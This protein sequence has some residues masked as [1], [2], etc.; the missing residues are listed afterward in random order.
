VG[1][2][3]VNESFFRDF[4]TLLPVT[5]LCDA[6]KECAVEESKEIWVG[7]LLNIFEIRVNKGHRFDQEL[8][9][10]RRIK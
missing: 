9:I 5:L 10:V 6:L 2:R 3:H 4:F 7:A 1:L 8:A